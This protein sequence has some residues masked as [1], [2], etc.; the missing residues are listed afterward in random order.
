MKRIIKKIIFVLLVMSFFSSTVI[1]DESDIM[2]CAAPCGNCGEMTVYQV[3]S[4]DEWLRYESTYCL[5]GYSN[6][7][8]YVVFRYHTDAYRYCSNCGWTTKKDAYRT[9]D[10]YFEH[11]LDNAS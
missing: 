3:S 1:A 7:A 10:Y 4:K 8:D 5:H 11:W 6:G 2:T 9:S